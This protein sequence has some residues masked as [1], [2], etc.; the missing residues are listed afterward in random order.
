MKSSCKLFSVNSFYLSLKY[1]K[2]KKK[3]LDMKFP[4]RIAK[5]IPMCLDN[6]A[7][8]LDT[9]SVLVSLVNVVAQ[10]SKHM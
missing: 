8:N 1:V 3:F 4:E 10:N 2:K 5:C 6:P 9:S 7:K